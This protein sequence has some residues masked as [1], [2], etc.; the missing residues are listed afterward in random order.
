M[1]KPKKRYFVGTVFDPEAKTC[2]SSFLFV[3]CHF[4][5]RLQNNK[6]IF[7][8]VACLP[9]IWRECG[10]WNP[11]IFLGLPK[12]LPPF[13]P[14]KH[15]LGN[16]N[17]SRISSDC[18]GLAPVQHGFGTLRAYHHRK[19]L[20][21]ADELIKAGWGCMGKPLDPKNVDNMTF[22]GFFVVGI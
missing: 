7:L 18:F 22:H 19:K 10:V 21:Q 8:F 13:L 2:C 5:S 16:T 12:F 9:D 20:Q 15:P 11:V 14:K 4:G 3:N 17:S 6:Q 1:M